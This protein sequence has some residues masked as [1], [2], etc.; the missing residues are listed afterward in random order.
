MPFIRCQK[1]RVHVPLTPSSTWSS[2]PIH[3]ARGTMQSHNYD[4][5]PNQRIM[6]SCHKI[7]GRATRPRTLEQRTAGSRQRPSWLGATELRLNSY[8][9]CQ[10]QANSR[11]DHDWAANHLG[12]GQANCAPYP[13]KR[14]GKRDMT[15]I[16]LGPGKLGWHSPSGGNKCRSKENR[17]SYNRACHRDP[18]GEQKTKQ[19][20]P[21]PA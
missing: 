4:P 15:A 16:L 1:S 21:Q 10:V 6:L 14:R 9:N 19:S 17:Q 3:P 7:R 11:G 5:I 12:Q 8:V 18:L 2:V 20:R 13:G